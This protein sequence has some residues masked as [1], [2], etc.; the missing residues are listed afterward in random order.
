MAPERLHTTKPRSTLPNG[1]TGNSAGHGPGTRLVVVWISRTAL[2]SRLVG[3]NRSYA[4][5]QLTDTPSSAPMA[6]L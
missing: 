2:A 1:S 4:D 5:S 6:A 3:Q